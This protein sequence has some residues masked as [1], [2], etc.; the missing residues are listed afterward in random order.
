[1]GLNVG[2]KDSIIRGY[3][4]RPDME[5]MK[6]GSQQKAPPLSQ[7]LTPPM[8]LLS[9]VYLGLLT[10]LIPASLVDAPPLLPDPFYLLALYALA[11]LH[12]VFLAEFWYLYL[13]DDTDEKQTNYQLYAFLAALLPPLRM[14]ARILPEKQQAWIPFKGWCT[15][16]N[17]LRE[18]MAKVFYAPMALIA[19]MVIPLVAMEFLNPDLVE[20]NEWLYWSIDVAYRIIWLAFAIEYLVRVSIAFN[21][22]TYTKLHIIDLLIILLPLFA[23]MRLLRVLRVANLLKVNQLSRLSR[24]YRLRSG[25]AKTLRVLIFFRIYRRTNVK[26][27]EKYLVKLEKEIAAHEREI[28]RLRRE[29]DE[30]EAR[31]NG[32]KQEQTPAD[33]TT[34]PDRPKEIQAKENVDLPTSE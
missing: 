13:T 22:I 28:A 14:G 20:A 12:V 32:I 18:H 15:V 9:F 27:L 34:T 21:R 23:F 26:V 16:S 25:F 33:E 5:Y 3:W 24:I 19:L 31:L 8:V 17:E 4:T 1:M 10:L 7:R 11:G 6:Q 29:I 30:V 2:L